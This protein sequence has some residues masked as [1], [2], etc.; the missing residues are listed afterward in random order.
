VSVVQICS[1]WPVLA[2]IQKRKLLVDFVVRSLP[3]A[4]NFGCLPEE[5]V[6]LVRAVHLQEFLVADVQVLAVGR[7]LVLMGSV[8][9]RPEWHFPS[10]PPMPAFLLVEWR[11]LA[12]GFRFCYF[13][14][15]GILVVPL[16]ASWHRLCLE[17]QLVELLGRR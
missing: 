17:P 3:V 5:V 12:F 9:S 10:V 16:R 2:M 1:L 4:L 15:V 11:F 6:L 13:L 14:V 7:M 8:K